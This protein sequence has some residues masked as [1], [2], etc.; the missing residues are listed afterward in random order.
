LLRFRPRKAELSETSRDTDPR[1]RRGGRFQG[2]TFRVSC[3]RTV[4]ALSG[5]GEMGITGPFIKGGIRLDLG[6]SL[7]RA[8]CPIAVAGLE[9]AMF[10][11]R[12]FA[13]DVLGRAR[14]DIDCADGAR[15]PDPTLD[16]KEELDVIRDTA[17][18][19]RYDWEKEACDGGRE[20]AA[21][22]TVELMG[23]FDRG[24]AGLSLKGSPALSA[25]AFR[26]EAG[27]GTFNCKQVACTA[28][29]LLQFDP[30]RL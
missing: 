30:W 19:L 28:F 3:F 17:E 21:E 14:L 20:D 2:D 25:S 29:S 27:S 16:E 15:M 11:F 12:S 6:S 23:V 10:W 7:G 26:L 1:G 8:R 18:L 4:T 5:V 13:S 22:A 24:A 9:A